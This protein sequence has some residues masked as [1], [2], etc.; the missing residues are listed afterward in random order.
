MENKEHR[1]VLK[2]H[3]TIVKYWRSHVCRKK[4]KSFLKKVVEIKK[5]VEE[6]GNTERKYFEYIQFLKKVCY[7]H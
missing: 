7:K 2:A 5:I 3:Q 1:E 4:Q 6:L